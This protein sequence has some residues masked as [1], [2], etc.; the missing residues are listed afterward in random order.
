[1]DRL[2]ISITELNKKN[3]TIL[4]KFI[5]SIVCD[6]GVE[7]KKDAFSHL[8]KTVLGIRLN[9][10]LPAESSSD[11]YSLYGEEVSLDMIENLPS[12]TC[13]SIIYQKENDAEDF[14]ELVP[15]VLFQHEFNDLV[16]LG[17]DL[18]KIDIERRNHYKFKCSDFFILYDLIRPRLGNRSIYFIERNLDKE[19]GVLSKPYITSL[20]GKKEDGS[21][22]YNG[23]P[24]RRFLPLMRITDDN[25]M[26]IFGKKKDDSSL[27]L[28]FVEK[29]INKIQN[30]WNGKR[31]LNS[32]LS[33]L[34]AIFDSSET[35][36][37][38]WLECSYF[39]SYDNELRK[40][41]PDE[42]QGLRNTLQIYKKS[43]VELVQNIVFHGGGQ[44]LFYCVFDRKLN[45][46]E[47]YHEK[48][49]GFDNY[50]KDA[51]FLRIGV[52]DFGKH[53]IVDTYRRD[54]NIDAEGLSTKVNNPI[55]L[56][57]FFDKDS[58]VT[59]GL[60]HLDMRYSARLGLKTFV[61]TIIE[62]D[63]YFRAESNDLDN[64]K[65]SKVS[66]QTEVKGNVLELGQEVLDD[67]AQGTHYE[68]ILPI[69]ATP[70][71]PV[72]ILPFQRTSLQA[73]S[74]RQSFEY[75][76]EKEPMLAIPLPAQ[77]ISTIAESTSK[78]EQLER[79]KNVC[80]KIVNDIAANNR[81]KKNDE[82]VF[83]FES[84]NRIDSSV[85][86]KVFSY[87]QLNSG[88]GFEKIILVNTT[89]LF[90]K[91]C[92]GWI[93]KIILD[94]SVRQVW[95]RDAA[96]I[97]ISENMFTRVI[98]GET[99]GELCY[100]NKEI[101]KFYCND[102]F[103]GKNDGYQ[104]IKGWCHQDESVL[105]DNEIDDNV[106]RKANRFILPYDLMIH[107][108][109]GSIS[110]FESFLDR[111]LK[112]R[113]GPQELGFLVNHENTYIGNKI[114]VKNYYEAD[115]MFQNN[116]F[117]ERFAYLITHNIKCELESSRSQK[118]KLVIIGYNLYSEILIKAIKRSLK[119]ESVYLTIFREEKDEF[120][121]DTFFD[122]DI[123]DGRNG[124]V[125]KQ[126]ILDYPERFVFV[127][128][129]PI[130]ATL[131]TNDKIMAFFKQW[132]K[133]H[134]F[135]S[136]G[137]ECF[138]YNHCVIVVRDDT[139]ICVTN[140][141]KEQKWVGVDLSKR[142]IN[143]AYNNAIEIHYTIQIGC[144]TENKEEE[145]SNWI[146]RLN[147]T[148]S[149]PPKWWEEK[150]V[151]FTENS[152]INS[153]NL[154]GVP[155][156]E[157]VEE[158]AHETEL[159]RLFTLKKYI[160]KGH[161]DV[162]N[163]HHKYYVDTEA[164][165]KNK[166]PLLIE[167][168]KKCVKGKGVFN[169]DNLNVIITPNVERESDL[170]FEVNRVIFEGNA[171]I[172][173]LDVNN[174]RN[175]MVHKLSFLKEIHKGRVK[176][177][178]V[179]QAL[180]TGETYRKSKSYL[181]SIVGDKDTSF[182][183]IITIVNRLSYARNQEIKN[184][185]NLNMYA[186]VNLYYPDSREGEL[187]CELC[188]LT[189]YY[190]ELK[191]R[192]VLDSCLSAISKNTEKLQIIHKN[193][194][195]R[196]KP[197]MRDFL[198]LVITHEIYYR[199]SEI[200]SQK[201]GASNGFRDVY[202][203][204][205]VELNSIYSQMSCDS[206]RRVQGNASNSKINQKIDGWFTPSFNTASIDILS[207]LSMCF[208]LKLRVD[209]TISFL[210]VISSP[211]LSKYIAIRNYAHEKLLYELFS[212][213][214]R[215]NGNQNDFR[216]DDL[217]T[218]KSIL[219]SL[220][221]LKSNALV[222]K[223]VIVGVWKVLGKIIDNID[224]EKQRLIEELLVVDQYVKGLDK[225]LLLLERSQQSLFEDSIEALKN[226]KSVVIALSQELQH[227]LN[228]M[229]KE[230]IIMD[231]SR[232]VQFFIK[233]AIVEDDAKATFLGELL[234][235]G[236]EMSTFESIRI[237][238]TL[239]SMA[240]DGSN[241]SRNDL[242]SIYNND[243][244]YNDKKIFKREYTNFLVWLFYDNTTI[245]R[246]TLDNFSKELSKDKEC[247]GL[248][249]HKEGDDDVLNDINVFKN[250]LDKTE[251]HF[252]EKV[253]KEYYYSSFRPYL[254]NEDGIN[255]VQKLLYVV[256]A[257]LKLKDLT[258][259]KHKTNIETDVKDL[260]E[261]L[262][263]IVGADASFMT[264]R[265]DKQPYP[266]SSFG[267][268][269]KQAR[270]WDYDNWIFDEK[271][272]SYRLCRFYDVKPPLIIKYNMPDSI[273]GDRSDLIYRE[274]TDLNMHSLGVF[275][276]TDPES[277]IKNDKAAAAIT[278]LFN[279]NNGSV[280][281]EMDF[282]V[283][284]QESGRLLLLLKNEISEYV[285]EYLIKDKVFDLWVEKITNSRKFEKAYSESAHTFKYVYE[286]MQEFENLNDKTLSALSNTWFFLTNETINFMYSNIEKNINKD[287]ATNKNA[288]KHVL[289]LFP[290]YLIDEENTLGNTF[291]RKFVY[292]L[293]QLLDRRWNSDCESNKNIITINGKDIHDYVIEPE[294]SNV[295]VHCNKH[296]MRTF[297]AQCVHNSLSTLDK[298]GHRG[299]YEVKKVG[300]TI[301][302]T[303]ITIE[304]SCLTEY[305]TR[306]EKRR[307]TDRFIQKKKYIKKMYCE[308]YSSTTLT[309]LQGF[310]NYMHG[311]FDYYKCD[312]YFNNDNNFKVTI[313]FGKNE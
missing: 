174:W 8:N 217:K 177:H 89:D 54:K 181:F 124:D 301:T 183:S 185:V 147:N 51:R 40:F 127:T 34:N 47:D 251:K 138:V 271:Y 184:D 5:K 120:T 23:N 160:Y 7:N 195:N 208:R 216:Y 80:T 182:D 33:K 262:S 52:F 274:K 191:K 13:F 309:S 145:H 157:I 90:V 98:W 272:Y 140:K 211:P 162:L 207:K 167:W 249:Y 155:E 109:N 229:D 58:I 96:I 57:D 188:R 136:L 129:V 253:E 285:I 179:D 43:I 107:V 50:D 59:T 221:F 38:K 297:I 101:Q 209:K 169:H 84:N 14:T 122:F 192:T 312:Y 259:N 225:K 79:I 305:Y 69:K 230:S 139:G 9:T 168:L 67:Y 175:N 165:V 231:F 63:G 313:N 130:G 104:E 248:F 220:S 295:K 32:L 56:R 81:N 131:S 286:E 236:I 164:F 6:A 76:S 48:I 85:L 144:T 26:T 245:I 12:E 22:T 123:D 213:I 53:G 252:R 310:V 72:K 226:E 256:Y 186:F 255:Y 135:Q 149:F 247:Y 115:M 215:T 103:N 66:I 227:D 260:L 302:K 193:D 261:I 3:W 303:C 180:L 42:I 292:I 106:I 113:I 111:L 114:I 73:D 304:D 18:E 242:F 45:F 307:R 141:E 126:E 258:N 156:A 289:S 250:K 146:R 91:E 97:I 29:S 128:I 71:S 125:T 166:T 148:I 273:D 10:N 44:G 137:N 300:I 41:K 92:F 200:A 4:Y 159:N 190:K 82:I 119:N 203:A 189:D 214:S 55:S 298:H 102:F 64:G 116:F 39:Y 65:S 288:T 282:R 296:I 218:V 279:D 142:V 95:S 150:Y 108:K 143:T 21:S 239:L 233:N 238:K 163:C 60:S 24:S 246:K 299:Q 284:F 235:Q 36:F 11:V 294:L 291:S 244:S 176:Y 1:M 277:K 171:L 151:N 212:I 293:E 62:N 88:Q 134:S 202:D 223:D 28:G 198:R 196:E 290:S 172:I 78:E 178:Y 199:I 31:T 265:K 110:L 68:I 158:D 201:A 118:K 287:S 49:L 2:I 241:S 17:I 266:I 194:I 112:R 270:G 267:K 228:S 222:R 117:T 132:H 74:F 86:F 83:D 153:Q 121:S 269:G 206:H 30:E 100:I 15:F 204:F 37:G 87:L 283:D 210:K 161:I 205:K 219:K 275:M 152:S 133:E 61:K 240:K 70:Y 93:T 263:A 224:I 278:F 257:K 77:D 243:V 268:L 25:Y 197:S 232:D 16:S 99:C 27:E 276:I 35:P 20:A 187:Y 154:M 46:T 306:E 264:I 237:S 281:N 94:Q 308:K 234:R 254:L 311:V 75:M 173:Y 19:T 105:N 280:V 170:V